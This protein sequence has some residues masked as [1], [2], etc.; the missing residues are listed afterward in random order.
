ML[1]KAHVRV[2]VLQSFLDALSVPANQP[3]ITVLQQLFK[4]YTLG[5]INDRSLDLVSV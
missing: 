3:A 5:L 1:L 4:L 2:F